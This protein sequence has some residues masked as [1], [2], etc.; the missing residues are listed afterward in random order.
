MDQKSWSR[1]KRKRLPQLLD[2]PTARR[3]LRDVEV[4]D[5]PAIVADEQ[6]AIKRIP[7]VIVGT[8]KKSMA[9]IA[10]L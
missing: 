7:K 8:V 3:M 1:P 10:S 5:T 2:D 9:A 6:E 4:Q